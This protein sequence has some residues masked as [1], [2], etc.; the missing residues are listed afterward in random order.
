M[1]VF[2]LGFVAMAAVVTFVLAWPVTFLLNSILTS[3][4][5]NVAISFAMSWSALL[6]CAAVGVAVFLPIIVSMLSL[7]AAATGSESPKEGEQLG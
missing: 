5:V 3:L 4:S 2:L 1:F 7:Q 6:V